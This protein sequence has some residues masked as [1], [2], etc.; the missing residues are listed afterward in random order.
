MLL[1][2]F[3]AGGHFPWGMRQS[4]KGAKLLRCIGLHAYPTGVAA[5]R[6]NQQRK[7]YKN[8]QQKITEPY[9]KNK[10]TSANGRSYVILMI[11]LL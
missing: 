4:S 3:A 8:Q 5:L 6:Y 7:N 11:L 2:I 10:T 9:I 1:L